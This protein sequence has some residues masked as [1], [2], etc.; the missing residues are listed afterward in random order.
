MTSGMFWTALL[1]GL[2]VQ[3]V[4]I[5]GAIRLALRDDRLAPARKEAKELAEKARTTTR[6]AA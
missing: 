2:A 6:P 3:A 1:L 4:V 5:Y